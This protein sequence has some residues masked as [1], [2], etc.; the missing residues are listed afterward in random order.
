MASNGLQPGQEDA[1]AFP[2]DDALASGADLEEVARYAKRRGN[3]FKGTTTEMNAQTAYDGAFWSNI[4]DDTLYRGNGADWI[5]WSRHWDTYTPV[6]TNVSGAPTVTARYA[7]A[8]GIVR[9]KI[10]VL[11]TGANFGTAP[12]FSLPVLAR[13]PV[14][15][16]AVGQALYGDVSVGNVGVGSVHMNNTTTVAPV[17][18]SGSPVSANFNVA[19]ALPFTWASGDRMNLD[20]SYEAA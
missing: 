4:T 15:F 13:A 10:A 3:L 19:A 1:P 7:I 2:E 17:T 16:E 5:A 6:L 12:L 20:F 11:L 14:G 8:S 9:V 18:W